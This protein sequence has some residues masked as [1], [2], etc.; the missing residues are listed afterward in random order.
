MFSGILLGGWEARLGE[1]EEED[2]RK[3]RPLCLL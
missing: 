2:E 1:D 3:T